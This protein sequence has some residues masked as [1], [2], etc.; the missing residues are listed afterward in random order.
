MPSAD[1][2]L[3]KGLPVNLDAERFVLGSILLDESLFIQVPGASSRTTSA[4]KS[5]AASS[6]AWR[7]LQERGERID[8]VTWPTS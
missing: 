6:G 1:S 7:D 4:S 2:T 5:T 3:D 8:R